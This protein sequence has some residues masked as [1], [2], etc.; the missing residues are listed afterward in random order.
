MEIAQ[1]ENLMQIGMMENNYGMGYGMGMG[2]GVI[3]AE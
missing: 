2:M 1:G 3:A